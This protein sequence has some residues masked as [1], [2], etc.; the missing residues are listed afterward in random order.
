[1]IKSSTRLYAVLALF[2]L[3]VSCSDQIPDTTQVST[4]TESNPPFPGTQSGSENSEPDVNDSNDTGGDVITPEQSPIS[5]LKAISSSGILSPSFLPE[6]HEYTILLNNSDPDFFI[7]FD[8]EDENSSAEV[9]VD[10][11]EQTCSENHIQINKDVSFVTIIITSEDCNSTTEYRFNISSPENLIDNFSFEQLSDESLP[12]AW[13]MN[14]SGGY[15][16]S[17]ENVFD[18]DNAFSF[19]S[20]TQSISGRELVSGPCPLTGDKSCIRLSASFFLPLDSVSDNTQRVLFSLKLYFYSD[21]ECN[22][23]ASTAYRTMKSTEVSEEAAWTEL[24]FD[25]NEVPDDCIAVK[26]AVRACYNPG[27][28]SRETAHFIDSVSL[29]EY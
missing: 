22:T 28:G 13:Q 20:L 26:A 24:S 5:T 11:E 17:S 12:I 19:D 14:S 21:V 6:T 15:V 7:K 23:P 10:G 2:L 16:I 9:S 8:K 1:M 25:I 29:I 27:L 18:G 4:N 3:L